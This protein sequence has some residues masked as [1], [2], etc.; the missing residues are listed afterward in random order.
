VLKHK[1]TGKSHKE[2]DRF[3]RWDSLEGGISAS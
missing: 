1:L 3:S 2:R